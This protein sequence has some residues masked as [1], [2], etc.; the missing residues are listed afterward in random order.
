MNKKLYSLYFIAVI[1]AAMVLFVSADKQTGGT[2]LQDYSNPGELLSLIETQDESYILID[3]RTER[4]Y[5][6][7]YIPTAGNIPFDIIADNLPTENREDLIILYCRSGR[8]SSIAAETLKDLGFSNVF[9]F[10]G[11][12]N[13][14]WG[15]SH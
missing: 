7:G 10:G 9:D 3:V 11:V 14:P 15:L 4:E 12:T 6:G 2:T 1:A 5:A 13:W 8:R